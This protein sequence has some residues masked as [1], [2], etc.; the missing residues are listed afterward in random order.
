MR[1]RD[2]MYV[3]RIRS[4]R[5]ISR[6]GRG[7]IATCSLRTPTDIL[8]ENYSIDMIHSVPCSVNN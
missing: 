5:Y 6:D 2:R 3:G 8:M 1:T 7:G 4:V